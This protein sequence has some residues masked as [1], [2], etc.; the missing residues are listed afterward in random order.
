MTHR[1]AQFSRRQ[2]YW[3]A[4]LALSLLLLGVAL[5]YQYGMD[6]APCSLCIQIRLWVAALLLIALSALT[7]QRWRWPNLVA[8]L[9][10]LGVS[11]GMA[12]TSYLLLSTERGWTLGECGFDLGLPGWFSPDRWLP[13]LFEVQGL[14]GY[15]PQL[16]LGMSMAEALMA[17]SVVLICAALAMTLSAI[18]WVREAD[19]PLESGETPLGRA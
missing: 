3:E 17:I 5:F 16:P 11:L 2:G 15:T 14:C 18:A 6:E 19:E 12:R 4:L 7:L 8:H 1:L 13:W 10:T 9:L